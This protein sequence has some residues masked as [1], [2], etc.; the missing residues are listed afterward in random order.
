[1]NKNFQKWWLYEMDLRKASIR[2]CPMCR[3][4]IDLFQEYVQHQCDA[5]SE[6]GSRSTNSINVTHAQRLV[7]GVRTASMWRMLRDWYQ[8]YEQHQYDAGSE[9]GSRSTN[10]INMTQAQRLVSGLPVS[11]LRKIYSSKQF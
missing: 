7:P 11:Q 9:T 8:E 10:S 2:S 4:Q 3:M 6:A 5:R 1:M